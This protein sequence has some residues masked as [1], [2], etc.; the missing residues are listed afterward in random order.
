MNQF[1][2]YRLFAPL[3]LTAIDLFIYRVGLA[4][5]RNWIEMQIRHFTYTVTDTVTT[6]GVGLS[7]CV[8][9]KRITLLANELVRLG[10]TGAVPNRIE[11]TVVV[12]EIIIS[13][14]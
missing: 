3:L 13:M 10:S 6:L 5:I 4:C 12:I 14:N 9:N 8:W 11:W 1:V 7:L 2:C